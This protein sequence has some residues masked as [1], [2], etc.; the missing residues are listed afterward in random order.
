MAA[1]DAIVSC[2]QGQ[3]TEVTNGSATGNI[4]LAVIDGAVEAQ[5]VASES[6][7]D[8]SVVGLP[9]PFYGA[10][11]KESTLADIFTGV[12][13]LSTAAYLYVRPLYGETPARVRIS[14]A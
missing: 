5:A 13:G 4:T 3:W 7:P 9:L 1:R 14:H 8:D 12:S 11:R 6:A 10:G 2:P